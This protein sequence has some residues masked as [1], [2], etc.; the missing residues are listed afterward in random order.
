MGGKPIVGVEVEGVNRLARALQDAEPELAEEL[1]VAH[2]GGAELVLKAALPL[3]PVRSGALKASLKATATGRSGRVKAGK[4]LVPYAGPVHF[5][6]P[7]RNIR[8]QPFL[9]DALDRRRQEV[10]DLFLD[11]VQDLADKIT[12]DANRGAD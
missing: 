12:D 3:V 2:I 4:K 10:E 8:P 5:G 7:K 1:K 11:R 9:Y 6:W